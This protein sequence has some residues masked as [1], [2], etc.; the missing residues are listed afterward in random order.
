[1]SNLDVIETW[2]KRVYTEEDISAVDDMMVPATDA[3]GLAD[4]A[5][6]GPEEFKVFVRGFLAL[7]TDID[8]R[9]DKSLEEGDWVHVLISIHAKSRANGQ[10]VKF[11]AQIMVRVVDGILVEGHNTVDFLSMFAQ[12]GLLPESTFSRC[13]G[14]ERVG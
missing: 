4:H 11:P 13:F 2:F 7:L 1:M 14:G 9:I 3:R 8:I 6:L 5:L 10:L 12:L